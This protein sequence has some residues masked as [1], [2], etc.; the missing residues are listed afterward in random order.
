MATCKVLVFDLEKGC[1]DS[2]IADIA[3]ELEYG[4]LWFF[5]CSKSEGAVKQK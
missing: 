2:V 4:T 1:D 5:T 3:S